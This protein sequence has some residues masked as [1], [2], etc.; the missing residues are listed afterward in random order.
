MWHVKHVSESRLADL[1]RALYEQSGQ[2]DKAKLTYEKA[3][4]LATAHTPPSAFARPFT[5]RKLGLGAR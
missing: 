3:Y 4:A 1:V 5:R 2:A